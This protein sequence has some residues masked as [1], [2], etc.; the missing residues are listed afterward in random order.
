[1]ATVSSGIDFEAELARLRDDYMAAAPGQRLN[2]IHQR[3][4]DHHFGPNRLVTEVCAVEGFARCLM[5]SHGARGR[6]A[7]LRAYYSKYRNW[8]ASSLVR[9][10][11]AVKKAGTPQEVFGTDS[12]RLYGHAIGFRNLLAHECTYLGLQKFEPLIGACRA[13]LTGLVRLSGV[14]Q[15]AF[16]G[17]MRAG[18]R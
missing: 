13:V 6:E 14:R 4:D 16:R 9:E 12:W 1:M 2:V 15:R 5:V 8:G 17:T 11:L 7:R 18:G 3:L 10:Y